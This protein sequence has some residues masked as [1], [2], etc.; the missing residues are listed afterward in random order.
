MEMLPR[1][2]RISQDQIQQVLVRQSDS[3]VSFL[4]TD[5]MDH[6]YNGSDAILYDPDKWNSSLVDFCLDLF[7]AAQIAHSHASRIDHLLSSLVQSNFCRPELPRNIITDTQNL[8]RRL[9]VYS[10]ALPECVP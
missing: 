9:P 10:L 3:R 2:D 8:L 1:L 5:Q 7:D 4:F 6:Y